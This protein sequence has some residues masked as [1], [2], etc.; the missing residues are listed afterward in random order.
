MK[1]KYIFLIVT[2]VITPIIVAFIYIFIAKSNRTLEVL[3]LDRISKAP[4][5]GSMVLLEKNKLITKDDGLVYFESLKK[6]RKSYK[7]IK[8]DYQDYE[9]T[10]LISGKYNSLIVNME[11]YVDSVNSIGYID[12]PDDESIATT[13]VN[14]TGRALNIEPSMHLWLVVKPHGSGGWWPQ[15]SEIITRRNGSWSTSVHLGGSSG[16][17]FDIHLILANDTANLSFNNYLAH[18]AVNGHFPEA[19]LPAGAKSLTYITVQKR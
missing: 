9:G 13:P 1:K 12:S 17:R 5:S 15:T 6:G 18:G 10:V 3:V 11:L 14:V 2:G 19:P 8:D 4:I 7:V 16:E